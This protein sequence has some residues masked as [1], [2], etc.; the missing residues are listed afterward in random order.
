[1]RSGRAGCN[2]PHLRHQR[3]D[4]HLLLVKAG[5]GPHAQEKSGG[6]KER[7]R[8]YSPE[9]MKAGYPQKQVQPC[10]DVG[11]NKAHQHNSDIVKDAFEKVDGHR[12]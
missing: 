1:M 6:E 9:E 7:A 5:R 4:L 12:L 10:A 8:D 3:N 2:Q 11:E